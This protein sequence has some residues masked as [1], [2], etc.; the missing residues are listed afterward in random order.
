MAYMLAA[1]VVYTILSLEAATLVMT[2]QEAA[3]SEEYTITDSVMI[4]VIVAVIWPL[5]VLE[6]FHK[7]FFVSDV[8]LITPRSV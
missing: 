7:L 3:S 5:L 6:A 2:D 4:F 8:K 1:L